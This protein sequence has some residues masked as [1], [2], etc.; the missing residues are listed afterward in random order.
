M[1]KK[2]DI[3]LKIL[4][5]TVGG[6]LLGDGSVTINGIA[7]IEK[8]QKGD[9]VFVFN[10]K[11]KALLEKTNA[12]AAC[13][14]DKIE[15][16]PIPI[17]LCKNPN[18]AF[19]KCI[20][21]FCKDRLHKK[22]GVHKLAVIGEGVKLGKNVTIGAMT[23]VGDNV[24][25]GDDS[26][27]HANVSIYK[28]TQIGERVIIHSGSVIGADGFGYEVGP[29]GHEK[30]PQIGNVIIEDDVELGAAVMVDK[31]KI[32]STVIGRGTKIDN[33]VQ[34]AHNVKIG[35]NCVIAA[36]CG[37]SGSVKIGNNVAMG[38]Q[39]GIA[40]HVE[41]GDNAILAAKCGVT[42]SVPSNT[43]MWGIPARTLKRAKINYALIDKLPEFYKKLK[44]FEKKLN[45]N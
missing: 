18:L 24:E 20:E 43:I 41:I 44:S 5:D 19:K 8:A 1:D 23:F 2:K 45:C 32:G 31:A 39:V 26:V 3:T 34:V 28:N 13:V 35:Q 11:S 42:K 6:K 36:Q 38:G 4:A 29:R 22:S 40:D 37:I 17:I 7:D 21:L 33:L 12:T 14:T 9:L 16:A 30:I 27:I 10:S 15:V 25:I